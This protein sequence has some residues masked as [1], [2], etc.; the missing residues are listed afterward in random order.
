MSVLT[1][2]FTCKCLLLL[3]LLRL[4]LAMFQAVWDYRFGDEIICQCH[5]LVGMRVTHPG[6]RRRRR[7]SCGNP[8][9]SATFRYVPRNYCCLFVCG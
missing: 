6:R 3:L 4:L 7:G 9:L 2:N 8:L 1:T 5:F